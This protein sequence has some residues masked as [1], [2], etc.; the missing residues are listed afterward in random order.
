M[1]TGQLGEVFSFLRTTIH[2]SGDLGG[3][4]G[5]IW[6]ITIW[7]IYRTIYLRIKVRLMQKNCFVSDDQID[8]KDIW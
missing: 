2:G 4:R 7:P 8:E 6:K 1:A 5:E 3:K